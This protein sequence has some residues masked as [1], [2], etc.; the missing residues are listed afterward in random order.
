MH[1]ASCNK[2][3]DIFKFTRLSGPLPL[4]SLLN[5]AQMYVRRHNTSLCNC[6][7]LLLK[8]NTKMQISVNKEPV[9]S[10]E[11]TMQLEMKDRFIQVTNKSFENKKPLQML[12][13]A[14]S[15]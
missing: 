8:C 5:N 1:H 14:R 13:A 11:N 15:F 7:L 10:A 12:I 6:T 4:C 9:N 2:D 3:S